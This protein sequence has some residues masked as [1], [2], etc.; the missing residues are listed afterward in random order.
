MV[1]EVSRIV[2]FLRCVHFK[3]YHDRAHLN[4]GAVQASRTIAGEHEKY[5]YFINLWNQFR[6]KKARSWS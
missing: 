3:K 6:R 2:S 4:V 1:S 5:H